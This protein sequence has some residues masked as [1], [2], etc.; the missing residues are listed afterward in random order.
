MSEAAIA[1]KAEIV[2]QTTDMLNAAQSAIVVDY[3]G[4]T[5]AE[6]TDLRKQLRDAGIQMSVI[7]NKILDRAVEGTDYEDLRSTFV[8]PTAVAFSDEDP[9]APA[10]I[11][12]KFADDHDALEIKGGFIEKSVKTLDEINEYANM[13]GR[14]ELLSMLASALQDPMRKIARAVKAI[15]DKEDEAA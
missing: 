7:K 2:K 13:P 14:E 4:L 8:G 3:R 12:K 11:L 10:K 9:I 1:K 6:V 15:A 5:V